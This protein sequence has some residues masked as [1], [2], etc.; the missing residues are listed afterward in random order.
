MKKPLWGCGQLTMITA[1]SD[2][3]DKGQLQH[4]YA[5]G[6]Q[7]S[8]LYTICMQTIG[9]N[10]HNKNYQKNKIKSNYSNPSHTHAVLAYHSDNISRVRAQVQHNLGHVKLRH[11]I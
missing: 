5:S 1:M 3:F 8:Q 6:Y 9:E 7:N 11:C 10:P 2:T 4:V